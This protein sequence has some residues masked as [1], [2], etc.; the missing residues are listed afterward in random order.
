MQ[1]NTITIYGL[2]E[3]S[4]PPSH[5]RT[6]FSSVSLLSLL[7]LSGYFFRDYIQ[8]FLVVVE[9]QNGA[10]V[11]LALVLLYFFVSLPFAWGYIIVNIATGYLYGYGH[12]RTAILHF[13]D[14]LS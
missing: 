12:G 1:V 4:Q 11:F 5:S 10:V 3:F 13:T 9:D 2:S 8:R 7:F 6:F 14:H